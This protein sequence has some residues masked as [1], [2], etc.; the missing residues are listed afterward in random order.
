MGRSP[1]FIGLGAQRCGTSWI[2]AC[3]YDHPQVCVPTKEIHF[4][5]RERNWQRGREWYERQFGECGPQSIA[6]EYSTSYFS[7]PVAAERIRSLY[8]AAKLIV[9]L[10]DPLQRIVSSYMNDIVA[11]EMSPRTTL[12][13]AL[14]VQPKYVEE[15]R[16]ATHLERYLQHFPA[17]QI[18]VLVY[19]DSLRDPTGFIRRVYDFIGV[20]PGFRSSMLGQRVGESRVPR[21]AWVERAI[22]RGGWL[23]R[24]R[25][26]RGMWWVAKRA[27]VGRRLRGAN[28]AALARPELPPD[29]RDRLAG[30]F[31]EEI[32][33]LERFLNRDLT[34]WTQ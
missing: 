2:Y 9:S 7:S 20:D 4:F 25:L 8:P 32:R 30:M 10:R 31:A 12:M 24:R 11:G 26:T 15:G 29:E 28:T 27:G 18:L 16:Y 19:E 13:D 34:A 21:S 23:M 17:S 14:R 5:S 22:L 33:R 6:G 1:D 3:L